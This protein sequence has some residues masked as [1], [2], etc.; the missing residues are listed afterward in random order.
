MESFFHFL[1]AVNPGDYR[2]T[3]KDYYAAIAHV[4][5]KYINEKLHEFL[6]K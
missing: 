2:E 6:L 3:F 4:L 1:L 5:L